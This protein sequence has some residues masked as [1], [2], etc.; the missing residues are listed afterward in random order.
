MAALDTVQN[1]V[2]GNLLENKKGCIT[3]QIHPSIPP[4]SFVIIRLSK[5]IV[6]M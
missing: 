5:G 3:K 6:N 4:P 2:N 1:C